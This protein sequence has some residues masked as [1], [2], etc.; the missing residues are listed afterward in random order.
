MNHFVRMNVRMPV[1]MSICKFHF[2]KTLY[3]TT[4]TDIIK[5]LKPFKLQN[6]IIC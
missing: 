2:L 3:S 5:N 1:C 6:K 4:F